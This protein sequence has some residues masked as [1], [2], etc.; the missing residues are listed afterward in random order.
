MYKFLLLLS[1]LLLSGC[2]TKVNHNT[3][4]IADAGKSQHLEAGSVVHLD[5]S[6]SH[7]ADGDILSFYWTLETKPVNSSAS[8]SLANT[9][10]PHFT[11]DLEGDYTIKLIVSDGKSESVPAYVKI[12]T[13]VFV[14]PDT[15]SPQ[16]DNLIYTPTNSVEKRPMLVIRLEF[17]DQTFISG[18][19]TWQ[20]ILFGKQ[21]NQLN[22]YYQEV[23]HQQFEFEPV[24][25]NGNVTDGIT[26]ISF[27]SSDHPDADINANDFT[28]K[29]HPFLKDAITRVSNAGFDFS[30]YDTKTPFGAITP[31]E[32]I[33]T[34]IMAGEEDAYSGGSS[35]NGV[36][37][38]QW[39]TESK[40]T[41]TVDG[42]SV[43]SCDDDGNYAIFGERHRD[44]S[45]S[46]DAT[47]GIIAHELGHSTFSLPDL[48]DTNSQ[49]GG[50]SYYGLMSNGS[51][52]MVGSTG[53]AGDTPTHFCAWSK[54][55]I[56]WYSATPTPNDIT[57]N[58]LINATGTAD[59]NIIKTP[60]SGVSNEYFLIE[61]RGTS[62]YDAG[63]KYLST[64]FQGGLAVWHIDSN[65]ISANLNDNSVNDN[66]SHKGVDLEEADTPSL[67]NSEGD[68]TKNLF[69]NGNKTEFTPNT[70]PGSN[71]YS[72]ERTY[73]FLTDISGPS[74]TM[75]LRI[76]NPQR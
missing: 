32:L 28:S 19:S 54:I 52:G 4:P 3:I 63:L 25:D 46:H 6:N 29:L 65:T 2:D 67:D 40:F 48:Y 24:T 33:V 13:I 22:H 5:G 31:D 30:V 26:T 71:L 7:D 1:L 9:A 41:P 68:P 42:V 21:A 59:Y 56:G 8:L 58:H 36:W 39:C 49:Y 23:S 69:Y 17:S 38:H 66:A 47:V 76:N 44:S 51:W 16:M 27:T 15:T 73:I 50:I 12:D 53:Q 70:F 57:T 10:K 64:D 43:M 74:D 11:A 35:A 20:S 62:G 18:E 61:N 75:T 37:A 55:D 72:N 60:V 45:S 14:D 34:F